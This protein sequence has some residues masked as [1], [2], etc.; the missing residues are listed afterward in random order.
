[1]A[2]W[3]VGRGGVDSARVGGG[4]PWPRGEGVRLAISPIARS[5]ARHPPAAT[6]R[7]CPVRPTW[8][9]Q[10]HTVGFCA[11]LRDTRA[12]RG[13]EPAIWVGV[14]KQRARGKRWCR[15]V[16][17][18]G[19]GGTRQAYRRRKP[20]DE[21]PG[22][23]RG[24]HR[25]PWPPRARHTS[26]LCPPAQLATTQTKKQ[27]HGWPRRARKL[28]IM[29]ATDRVDTPRSGY[30]QKK[31]NQPSCSRVHHPLPVPARVAA[32]NKN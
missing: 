23:T 17:D 20:G 4:L 9:S 31:K 25:P 16:R 15:A 29:A 26:T 12:R 1:M 27:Q 8:R 14:R 3:P 24:L 28:K 5:R 2:G 32:A 13:R 21:H 11:H 18:D 30:E 10:V 6:R 19:R 7:R 22:G